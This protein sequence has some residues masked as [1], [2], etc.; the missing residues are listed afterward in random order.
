V[1]AEFEPAVEDITT[2]NMDS[3]DPYEE[4]KSMEERVMA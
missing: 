1:N 3:I 2:N 4:L